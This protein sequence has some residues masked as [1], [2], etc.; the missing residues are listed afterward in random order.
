MDGEVDGGVTRDATTGVR[1][2]ID[3]TPSAYSNV[4]TY[5]Q[6]LT[7]RVDGKEEGS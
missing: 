5:I 2:S 4:Y 3:A 7:T 1:S 6:V